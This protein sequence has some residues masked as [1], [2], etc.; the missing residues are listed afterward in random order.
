VVGEHDPVADEH[1]VLDGHTFTDKTVTR[2][3]AAAS[4]LCALLHLDERANFG[5]V[6]NLATVEVG[7]AKHLGIFAQLDVRSDL[8]VERGHDWFNHGWTRIDTGCRSPGVRW[9]EVNH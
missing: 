5:L 2:D 4:N 9:F 7:E 8:L 3:F 1:L 6:A